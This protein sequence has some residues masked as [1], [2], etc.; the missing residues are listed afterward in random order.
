MNVL[1]E[2]NSFICRGLTVHVCNDAFHMDLP[3]DCLVCGHMVY[4]G[5]ITMQSNHRA[6]CF[7]LHKV[8]ANLEKA[9]CLLGVEKFLQLSEGRPEELKRNT[10]TEWEENLCQHI[11][12]LSHYVEKIVCLCLMLARK[13]R[14]SLTLKSFHL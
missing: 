8:N 13:E 10:E 4:T 14:H 1:S 3:G 6:H 2:G 9:L 12:F 7:I 5:L 11:D